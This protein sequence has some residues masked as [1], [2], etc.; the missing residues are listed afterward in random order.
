MID[1]WCW[2]LIDSINEMISV[3][4]FIVCTMVAIVSGRLGHQD[5]QSAYG[6]N[7]YWQHRARQT[8]NEYAYP[9]SF[10]GRSV[11]PKILC[12]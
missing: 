3:V 8:R 1:I 12:N 7:S 4:D 2:H 6:V 5:M 9:T 11:G 10:R